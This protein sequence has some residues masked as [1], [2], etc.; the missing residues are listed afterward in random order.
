MIVAINA[1]WL[2]AGSSLAPKLR[3]PRRARGVNVALVGA[4]ALAVVQ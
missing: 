4:S 1:T 2:L 3:D